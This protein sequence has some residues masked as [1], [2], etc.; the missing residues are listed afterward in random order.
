[1]EGALLSGARA[2][3]EV[4][5]ALQP[6]VVDD[7][8]APCRSGGQGRNPAQTQ[9]APSPTRVGFVLCTLSP[10]IRWLG[11]IVNAP[12]GGRIARPTVAR[13]ASGA[14]T[15]CRPCRMTLMEI[16]QRRKVAH[17]WSRCPTK[18]GRGSP[19]AIEPAEGILVSASQRFAVYLPSTLRTVRFAGWLSGDT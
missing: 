3:D 16:R 8:N 9:F 5:R 1:M 11:R 7:F 12:C 17:T 14:S 6:D 4:L 2:A 19:G 13:C 10:T 18:R 15:N